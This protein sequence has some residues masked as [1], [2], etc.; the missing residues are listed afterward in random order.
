MN[1]IAVIGS[2]VAGATAA[3]LA[4]KH[5]GA[6]I[7]VFERVSNPRAVGAGFLLQP[8]GLSVL[9]QTGLLSDVQAAGARVNRLYGETSTGSTV[10]DLQY[11]KLGKGLHGLGVDR[12]KVYKIGCDAMEKDPNIELR[13]GSHITSIDADSSSRVFIDGECFDAII[14]ATGALR[15]PPPLL[16]A[17]EP[18][19]LFTPARFGALWM[20]LHKSQD[21]PMWDHHNNSV[22]YN[23][24]NTARYMLGLMPCGP[25]SLTLFWSLPRDKQYTSM[26][27][28]VD[29]MV[30]ACPYAKGQLADTLI[31]LPLDSFSTARYGDGLM[32]SMKARTVPVFYIGDVAHCSSPQLGQGANLALLD[33]ATLIGSLKSDNGTSFDSLRRSQVRFYHW[34]SRAL[35]PLFQSEAVL[36]SKLRDLLWEPSRRFLPFFERESL[37]ALAGQKRGLFN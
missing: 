31:G 9:S 7:K 28:L 37:K 18:G 3:L 1:K 5:L 27:E 25:E 4:S 11:S 14:V 22:L 21:G 6:S 23:Q 35:T 30:K 26:G 29:E 13:F 34:A 16:G 33:A 32:E 24:Y 8:T 2:S 36:P 15:S 20:N 17:M 19:R 10:L 12:G